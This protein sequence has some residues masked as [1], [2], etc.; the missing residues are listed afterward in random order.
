MLTF[1]HKQTVQNAH[2]TRK[3]EIFKKRDNLLLINLHK[4]VE[5]KCLN[6]KN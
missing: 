5:K 1:A 2:N 6:P 4:I 3:N